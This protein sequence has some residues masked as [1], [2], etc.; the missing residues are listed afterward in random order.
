MSPLRPPDLLVLSVSPK[1]ADGSKSL[2]LREVSDEDAPE[3]S[4]ESWD[5]VAADKPLKLE[6]VRF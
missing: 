1:N 5:L 2:H 4:G 6:Q 3:T